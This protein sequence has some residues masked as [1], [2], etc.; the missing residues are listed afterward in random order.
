MELDVI[1][2][3]KPCRDTSSSHLY[4]STERRHL[5]IVHGTGSQ[6]IMA[7]SS[8]GLVQIDQQHGAGSLGTTVAGTR[9]QSPTTRTIRRLPIR[10]G[11]RRRS[12]A[13]R[14]R[15]RGRR[16]RC[17]PRARAPSARGRARRARGRDRVAVPDALHVLLDDRALVELLGD[18][19]GGRA[20]QLDAALVRVAVGLG[21]GERRQE[22]VVDVDH[23]DS[24]R[25]RG[26]RR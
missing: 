8:V 26:T 18:V 22:R 15:A 19:V 1:R 13:P 9:S 6:P 17:A 10:P 20:D 12:S 3:S 25:A 5:L 2:N 23:R 16:A 24:R 14:A 21:A 11:I 4:S 7:P